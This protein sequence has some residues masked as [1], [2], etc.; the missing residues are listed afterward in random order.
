MKRLLTIFLLA[1]L[2]LLL[3]A[4]PACQDAVKSSGSS[5]GSSKGGARVVG[6]S[7]VLAQRP[8]LGWSSWS[9]LGSSVT[10]E[11]IETQ[12]RE[13]ASKLK[14][15]GYIYVN[16]DDYWYLNPRTTVDQYGRW[17]ADP[18]KFPEGI[19]GV[20]RYVHQLGLKFGIYLNPGIPVAAVT[21]NTPIEGTTY[22]ARDIADTSRYE[23]NFSFGKETQ[24][25]ID[26]QK[27]GA[28]AFVNSWA[29]LLA[30]WQVDFLKLDG[31]N[32][33]GIPESQ[34]RANI[35]VWSRALRQSGR[36][37]YFLLSNSFPIT[38][39]KLLRQNANGWRIDSDIECYAS[40]PGLVN[41]QNIT[42]RFNDVPAWLQWAGPGGWNDLDSLDVGNGV[43][44]GLT[45]DERQSYMTLWAI[46]SAPLYTGD[47][48]TTLDAYGLRLLTNDEVLA[49][50]QQGVP[51]RPISVSAQQQ[52]WCTG[53]PD[54][55]ATV[56]LFNLAASPASITVRWSELGLQGSASVRDLWS[57]TNLGMYGSSFSAQ[58]N[59]HVA[60]LLHI[61]PASRSLS[62]L[63]VKP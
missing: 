51:G 13:L 47:D 33:E 32:A 52:V 1:G 21:R 17:V 23:T 2:L 36:P 56:A 15:H 29:S 61:T 5:S 54:G 53:E 35:E 30:R 43:R 12:A 37:I 3:V 38:E 25:F 31:I 20:S 27:P 58:L 24:Y 63:C 49:V 39:A 22:H 44:D 42:T 50:D 59:I 40:C 14:S 11:K 7:V 62:H 6:D 55:S 60:R 57:H 34:L 48:L 18:A 28:Q 26:Y 45:N 16:L 41:W 10:A 19:D 46:S 4:L 8:L 9:S